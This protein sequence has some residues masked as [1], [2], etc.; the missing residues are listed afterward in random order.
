MIEEKAE[1]KKVIVIGF[2]LGAQVTIQMLSMRPDL[3]DYAIINSALVRPMSYAKKWIRPSIRLTYPLVKNR[4]FSKV[5]SKTLYVDKEYFEKYY[6]ESSQMKSDT[7]IRILEENM[8]FEIPDNFK[9]A[10]VEYWLLSVKK[11]RLL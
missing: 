7:L 8:S 5:Q 3:I 10:K 9:K 6:D 1:G 2:S 11:K 4:W